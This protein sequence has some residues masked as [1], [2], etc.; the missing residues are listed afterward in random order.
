MFILLLERATL[1][2]NSFSNNLITC[3][4]LIEMNFG[5]FEGLT[6]EEI[7]DKNPEEVSKL[8]KHGFEYK[9]PNGE[10]LMIFT[11]ELKLVFMI[12]SQNH[13]NRIAIVSHSGTIRCILSEIIGESYKYHWN[14][15]I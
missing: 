6:L 7:K 10:S 2:G 14:F 5:D 13:D 3:D 15:Q 11:I 9:F 1:T 12:L 8:F 4:N